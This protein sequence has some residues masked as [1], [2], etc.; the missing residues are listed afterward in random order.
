[1]GLWAHVHREHLG[2]ELL[3][4]AR[5]PRDLR[6]ER[7]GGPRVHHVGVAGEAPRPPAV[8]LLVPVG[9]VGGRVH[10]Q[11]LLAR[12]DRLL[13]ADLAVVV[14]R[15]PERER[16]PEEAL[17]AHAPVAREAVHPILEARSHVGRVPAQ[18]APTR[19]QRLAMGERAHEPLPARHDLDRALALLEEL[20]GVRER[21]RL[22]DELARL[23]EQLD[24][25]PAR[26]V[27]AGAAQLVIARPRALRVHGLPPGRA[28]GHVEQAPVGAQHRSHR[29]LELPPPHDVGQIAE[30]AHHHEAR[31]LLALDRRVR[32]HRHARAEQRRE[33]LV[34]DELRVAL[35]VG[36]GEQGDAGGDQLRA[37]G[38]DERVRAAV[39]GAE[40]H[41]MHRAR[42]LAVLELGLRDGGLE[43]DVPERG[44]LELVGLAARQQPEKGP[45]RDAPRERP[46]RRVRARP[47]HR[48]TE[49]APQLLEGALVALGE[50]EAQLDEVR[51]RY[52]HGLGVGRLGR[53][54]ELRVI[55]NGGIALDPIVVLH[56]PLGG[57]TVVVPPH[58]VEDLPPAHPVVARERVGVGV[59]EDVPDVQRAAHGGRRRVDRVDPLARRGAV[60]AEGALALPGLAPALLEPLEA[61][62]LGHARALG[63]LTHGRLP[64][65]SAVAVRGSS[66]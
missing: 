55:G 56:A 42:A 4:D 65:R 34:A 64:R 18:L 37:G 45:L 39:D 66:R 1:M 52:R 62:L 5:L 28:P 27:D 21:L 54:A 13:V 8:G 44:R 7:G 29:Q 16:H 48:Q 61:R 25:P 32:H 24:D 57:E 30:R 23:L 35:V 58:R 20:H 38:L 47:V 43:V 9:H 53:R 26:L 14:D 10:G 11:L 59:G 40:A 6:G 17:A 15:V 49:P 12:E 19:D 50:L 63:A 41:A 2:I 46:D 33:H 60:E 51:A 31:A 36:V 22:A 3:L